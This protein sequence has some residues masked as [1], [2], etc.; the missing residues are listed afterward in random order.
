M[1]DVRGLVG[2]EDVSGVLD[3]LEVAVLRGHEHPFFVLPDRPAV[4]HC[5]NALAH[6]T[7]STSH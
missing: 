6:K 7:T 1:N 4:N 2:L 3:V 5:L